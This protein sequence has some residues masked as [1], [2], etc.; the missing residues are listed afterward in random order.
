M[1]FALLPLNKLKRQVKRKDQL[2]HR[3]TKEP[4]HANR[5]PSTFNRQPDPDGLK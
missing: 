2:F 3:T 4:R 5:Q 1:E